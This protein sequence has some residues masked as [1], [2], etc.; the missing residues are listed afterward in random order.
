MKF[1]AIIKELKNKI[2]KPIYFLHGDEPYFIDLITSYIADN[3]LEDSEKSFNQ[4]VVYGKD[5]V[6][7]DI[8]NA[9]KRFPMMSNH[10]VIIVK[11]AQDLK[12]IENLVYY[13][14]NPL[15]STILVINYKYK[16]LAKNK[17]LYKAIDKN[18]V[19]FESKKLYDNQIPAWI[20]NYLKEQNYTINPKAS[21][22]LTEF[23][24]NDLS[25]ISNE[26]DKLIITLPKGTEIK[27]EHIEENIGFSKDFNNFELQNAIKE[28]NVL[29]ANRIIDYFGKNQKDNPIILT[30]I[31]LFFYFSK[32]LSYHY[33]KDKSR[34]NAASVLKV[35]PFF[36][37]DYEISAKKYSKAKLIS[38]ISILREYDMK[39]KGLDNATTSPGDLLKEMMFKILH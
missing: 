6:V 19:I 1:E 17:K 33:L 28:R 39:S 22:L 21:V 11:E 36:V 3:V 7:E 35:N 4:T 30:I 24:G 23:L 27:A 20:N 12:K 32:V 14:Q 38:I 13:A 29:K 31:S 26:L 37:K 5:S 8:D 10:Q 16:K 15:K 18:G 9:A 25:K 34:N 2:Y